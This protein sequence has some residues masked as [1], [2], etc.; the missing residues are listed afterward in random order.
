MPDEIIEILKK[1]GTKKKELT[2]PESA[3]PIYDQLVSY[4]L[5]GSNNKDHYHDDDGQ[6]VIEVGDARGGV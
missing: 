5:G 1:I 4:G 6:T 3:K 2:K